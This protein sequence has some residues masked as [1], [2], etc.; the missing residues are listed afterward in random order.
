MVL[1][2]RA[3]L[4]VIDILHCAVEGYATIENRYSYDSIE[5]LKESGGGARQS[6]VAGKDYI[7]IVVS[8]KKE[9]QKKKLLYY[10]SQ[11]DEC[12][13]ELQNHCKSPSLS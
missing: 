6:R 3:F 2:G 4:F 13:S 10:V 5:S 7:Y 9:G 11:R 12:L 1:K 8:A